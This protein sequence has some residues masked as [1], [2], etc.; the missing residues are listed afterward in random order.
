MGYSPWGRKELDMTERLLCVFM[1]VCVCVCV[2]LVNA[3]AHQLLGNLFFL[4]NLGELMVFGCF[5]VPH[6]DSPVL[7]EQFPE[8]QFC[9]KPRTE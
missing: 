4:G 3:E 7:I 2:S 8:I 5:P 6:L 1:C 9:S